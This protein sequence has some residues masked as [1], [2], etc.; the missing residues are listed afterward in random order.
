[1]NVPKCRECEDLTTENVGCYKRYTHYYCYH[2]EIV[3]IRIS[4]RKQMSAR[5][6]KTSP[7]WCPLREERSV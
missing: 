1:M 3:K 7:K 6:A 2:P 4:H 5:E